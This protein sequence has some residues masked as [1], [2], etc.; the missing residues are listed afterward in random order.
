MSIEVRVIID[1]NATIVGATTTDLQGN[2]TVENPAFLIPDEHGVPNFI[3]ALRAM[4]V[5]DSETE[6]YI[7]KDKLKFGKAFLADKQIA[8][9]YKQQMGYV[10][11]ELPEESKLIL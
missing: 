1:D 4:G 2:V 7:T 3:P 8:Q 10:A 11:L 9:M 5:D 6:I